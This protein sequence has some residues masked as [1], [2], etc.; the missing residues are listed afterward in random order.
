MPPVKLISHTEN[1]SPT[2]MN[3]TSE[4]VDRVSKSLGVPPGELVAGGVEM[5]LRHRLRAAQAEIHDMETK[6]KVSSPRE[7]EEKIREGSVE[8]H[9]TW[10]D[11]IQY[12]NLV[13][14]AEKIRHELDSMPR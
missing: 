5:Y 4:L 14:Q 2:R 11:L 3:E 10:E 8:E 7:L 13:E 9:P 12:E 1:N 6:Y